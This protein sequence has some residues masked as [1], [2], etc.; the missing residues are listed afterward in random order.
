MSN[1]LGN[2]KTTNQHV[3]VGPDGKVNVDLTFVE[4]PL[5]MPVSEGYG[6]PRFEFGEKLGPENRYT[7]IRKLGWGMTSSIW[8]ARDLKRVLPVSRFLIPFF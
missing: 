8:L 5:G 3:S 7:I 6:L 4:E 2:T 1:D